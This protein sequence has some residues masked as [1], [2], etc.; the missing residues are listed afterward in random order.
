MG[1]QAAKDIMVYPA[2]A[3]SAS[4]QRLLAD[5]RRRG[6][7]NGWAYI[8][9]S[10]VGIRRRAEM[11][12]SPRATRARRERNEGGDEVSAAVLGVPRMLNA[13]PVMRLQSRKHLLPDEHTCS[14]TRTENKRHPERAAPSQAHP[15]RIGPAIPTRS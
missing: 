14:P 7:R 5:H 10:C 4:L 9:I 11:R 13:V 1:R 15:V 8:V 12:S 2:R 6:F 3:T